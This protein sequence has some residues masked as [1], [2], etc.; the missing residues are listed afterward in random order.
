MIDGYK[1][2][3]EDPVN[4]GAIFFAVC[5]GKVRFVWA[6]AECVWR[7]DRGVGGRGILTGEVAFAFG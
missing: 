5:R 4:P 2:K 3:L 7:G 6:C 1:A